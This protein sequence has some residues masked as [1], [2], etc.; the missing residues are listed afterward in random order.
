MSQY[1]KD[2]IKNEL[3]QLKDHPKYSSVYRKYQSDKDV[4][5]NNALVAFAD[6]F[7]NRNLFLE[8]YVRQETFLIDSS[9]RGGLLQRKNKCVYYV[10]VYFNFKLPDWKTKVLDSLLDVEFENGQ[11][12]AGAD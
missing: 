2:T 11:F 12:N 6:Y 4:M 7:Y 10:K 8:T 9:L 3:L 5:F 1:V